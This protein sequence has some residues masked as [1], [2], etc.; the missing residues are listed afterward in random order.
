MASAFGNVINFIFSLMGILII[1]LI[2]LRI[3]VFAFSKEKTVFATIINKQCYDKQ[4]Y[5]KAQAPF[6]KRIYTMTFLC[7]NKKMYFDVSEQTYLYYQ[8]NQSGELYY[9]GNKFLNFTVR[10][11]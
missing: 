7:K 1:L 11:G 6:S 3:I 10:K 2:V 9:K 4:I 8:I 5:K